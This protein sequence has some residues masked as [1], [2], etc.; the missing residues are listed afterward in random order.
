[1]YRIE[2]VFEVNAFVMGLTIF[3]AMVFSAIHYLAGR[4]SV[5]RV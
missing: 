4:A 5:I 1:M 3:V 2:A